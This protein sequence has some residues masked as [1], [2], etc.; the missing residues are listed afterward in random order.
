[1]FKSIEEKVIFNKLIGNNKT[2][3]KCDINNNYLESFNNK[4]KLMNNLRENYAFKSISSH[5]PYLGACIIFIKRVIRKLLKWYIE[6]ICFQQTKF[7][8]AVT[9]ANSD[10]YN[11]LTSIDSRTKELEGKIYALNETIKVLRNENNKLKY[12]IRKFE[13]N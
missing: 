3:I 4:L 10:I 7:N 9:E 11:Y 8:V 13:T 1:M 2:A 5:R 6:P 12:K